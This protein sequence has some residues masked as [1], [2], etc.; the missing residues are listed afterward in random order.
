MKETINSIGT[1]LTITVL[2]IAAFMIPNTALRILAGVGIVYTMYFH[3]D[4]IR[5]LSREDAIDEY[6]K[7]VDRFNE[8]VEQHNGKVDEEGG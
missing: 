8:D 1:I 2:I 3:D 6:N 5:S 7:E 4:Y